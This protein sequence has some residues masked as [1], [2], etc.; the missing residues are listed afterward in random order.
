MKESRWP[1]YT[2]KD[3]REVS[4][5]L[6][7]NNVNYWTGFE[8]KKFEKEFASYIK[9]KYAIA[10]SNGTVALE[11]ALHAI[12]IRENDEVIVTPRSYIA[13]VSCV[14][15][16]RAIPVF[17]DI[18]L[19]SQN[20]LPSSIEKKITN[21]TKAI[22]CVHLAGWP[23]E[24]DEINKIAKK[25]N[26]VVIEDCSQAHGAKYKDKFVG[27]LG[28]I[29]TFSF[30]ND[31]IMNTLGEGGIITTSSKKYWKRIWEYK[32]HGRDW[33]KSNLKYND[34]KFKWIVNSF[35]SNYRLTEAQSLVG[36]I[37]LRKLNKWIDIRN[38]N[39]KEIEKT[40]F[41]FNFIRKIKRPKYVKHAFYRYYIFVENNKLD[42]RWDRD[43][44]ISELKKLDVKCF[45]GSCPEIYLEKPFNKKIYKPNKRLVNAKKLGELGIA[46]L[47]H[48]TITKKELLKTCKSIEKVFS[49]IPII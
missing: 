18:D 8:G 17:A 26:L 5:V 24:M 40:C 32:D 37:Q 42:K 13:S 46:F 25:R 27:S 22:I 4:K 36:R 31:K 35:G 12:N 28:D 11:L 7:S 41:K 14:V 9:S 48:P 6:K 16:K 33:Y 29:G 49:K 21:K 23:C 44:I 39:A 10:V 19:C 34:N 1:F 3:V 45:Q 47:V 30:C 2:S 15:N 43:K 20:I 38:K